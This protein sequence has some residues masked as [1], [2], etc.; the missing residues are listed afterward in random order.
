MVRLAD[1][2]NWWLRL[3]RSAWNVAGRT[4]QSIE[5]LLE[6]DPPPQGVVAGFE[7]P[8]Q[9]GRTAILIL[10]QTDAAIE[11]AG[12]RLAGIGREGAVYGSISVL[13]N[14][15]FESLYLSREE[16]ELGSLPRYQT[17][18][19]WVIQHIYLVP[20]LVLVSCILPVFWLHPWIERKVRLRL[21]G[22]P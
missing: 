2:D 15:R 18:N 8:F 16:Y 10:G 6:A 1:N 17:M 19:L 4:R 14:G 20:L 11:L 3:R 13:Y 22:R 12:T 21:D 9:K 7:S 5:D